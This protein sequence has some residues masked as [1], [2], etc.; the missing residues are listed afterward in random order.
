MLPACLFGGTIMSRTCVLATNGGLYR[1]F[2]NKHNLN[3][4][5]YVSITD[6]EKVRGIAIGLTIIL[7]GP[8]PANWL[9]LQRVLEARAVKYIE[10]SDWEAEHGNTLCKS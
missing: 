4:K 10:E 8:R 3:P 2:V 9:D 7:V 1:T 5:E 6:H